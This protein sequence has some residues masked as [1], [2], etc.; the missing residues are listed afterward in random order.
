ML[1]FKPSSIAD[2]IGYDRE[3]GD[4]P[5][6]SEC[7]QNQSQLAT[8]LSD[9]CV[10]ANSVQASSRLRAS[11]EGYGDKVVGDWDGDVLASRT[12]EGG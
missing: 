6:M 7:L 10:V 9:S 2:E 11:M 4:V 1:S 8:Q 5:M 12:A 3:D